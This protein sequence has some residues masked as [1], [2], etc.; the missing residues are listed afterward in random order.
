MNTIT[1]DDLRHPLI[2]GSTRA[3]M[4]G[5]GAIAEHMAVAQLAAGATTAVVDTGRSF[6]A[7]IERC[8]RD[9]RKVNA[10]TVAQAKKPV[11]YWRQFD[12]RKF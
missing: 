7:H 10:G 2:M 1:E 8:M 6:E 3:G 5:L 12:K 9:G 11:P 4:T